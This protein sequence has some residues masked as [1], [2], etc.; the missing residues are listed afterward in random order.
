MMTVWIYIYIHTIRLFLFSFV[1]QTC[2]GV[3]PRPMEVDRSWSFQVQVQDHTLWSIGD[4][5][6]LIV[7]NLNTFQ[8]DATRTETRRILVTVNIS[9]TFTPAGH[10]PDTATSTVQLIHCDSTVDF[11]SSSEF[12]FLRL[13][14]E[15]A[16][17]SWTSIFSRYSFSSICLHRWRFR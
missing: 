11:F 16:C 12:L 1:I 13:Q 10:H 4:D 8:Q 14:L 2:D 3:I 7:W 9:K 17:D 15:C 5:G 6:K